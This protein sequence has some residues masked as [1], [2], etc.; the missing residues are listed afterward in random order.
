MT[1]EELLSELATL[2]REDKRRV[3]ESLSQELVDDLVDPAIVPG[4]TYE[5]WSPFGADEAARVLLDLL[6][7]TGDADARS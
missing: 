4:G 6:R 3:V 5:V 2:S 7:A 1:L